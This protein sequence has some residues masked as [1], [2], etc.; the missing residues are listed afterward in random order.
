[1][2]ENNNI[3]KNGIIEFVK[4]N[5]I[6][7]AILFFV[8]FIFFIDDNNVLNQVK[9]LEDAVNLSE[10]V[11]LDE[12]VF[13]LAYNNYSG[14]SAR[15][16]IVFNKNG[17]ILSEYANQEYD[18][19]YV[20]YFSDMM[21]TDDGKVCYLTTANNEIW[22]Y[23]LSFDNNYNIT[24]KKTKVMEYADY[25]LIPYK[26]YYMNGHIY[27]IGGIC[28][29]FDY[30]GDDTIKTETTETLTVWEIED[31]KCKQTDIVLPKE[32]GFVPIRINYILEQ[33]DTYILFGVS[34]DGNYLEDG[35]AKMDV[36]TLSK[37]NYAVLDYSSIC[38]EESGK[39]YGAY[40]YIS[41]GGVANSTT[42]NSSGYLLVSSGGVANSTTGINDGYNVGFDIV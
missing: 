42:V 31:N 21:K 41:S 14:G 12:N 29:M 17:E 40:M 6:L 35:L 4:N 7:L 15:R 2:E 37:E 13:F 25:A 18:A 38:T 39:N 28:C 27:G 36:I 26:W 22:Y 5:K 19:G 10:I 20:I 33:E 23:E 34:S 3:D 32:Q 8:V 30:N 1:M 9:L 11:V 24:E 16:A